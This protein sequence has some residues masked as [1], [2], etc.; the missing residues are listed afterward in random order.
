MQQQH[1]AMENKSI[2][3]D[4]TGHQFFLNTIWPWEGHPEGQGQSAICEALGPPTIVYDLN[5]MRLKPNKLR[6]ILKINKNDNDDAKVDQNTLMFFFKR[7][8]S[9]RA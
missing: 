9:R 2:A 8:R 3:V 1:Q 5:Q 6:L 4:A 7:K